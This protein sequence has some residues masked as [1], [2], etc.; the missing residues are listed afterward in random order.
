MTANRYYLI[1]PTSVIVMIGVF[2]FGCSS[3]GSTPTPSPDQMDRGPFTG[4][5]C[6]A[7]CWHGLIIG[8]SNENDVMSTLPTLTFINHNT[9][10][11]HQ[12]QSLPSLD[13][14][15]W[16]KGV[17]ITA[18]CITAEKQC[19]TIRV[20]ENALTDVVTVMNYNIRVEE[21]IK[22]LGNP[23]YIGFDRAG[24][25]QIACK[26]YLIW[27]EKQLVLTSQIFEGVGAVEKNCYVIRD[28]GKV[29]SGLLISEARYTSIRTIEVLL[30]S[31]AGKFFEFTETIP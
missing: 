6:T 30:S 20:V 19:V 31:P 1:Y 5:P 7:P 25:E 11:V 24:G 22:Y 14:S 18:N 27:K 3:F 29:P 28:T 10:N 21:A 16:G 17:E 15:I 2:L 26:V 12:M 4:I 13:P 23:D 9:I 8:Q